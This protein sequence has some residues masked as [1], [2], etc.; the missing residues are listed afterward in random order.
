MFI[1]FCHTSQ[2]IFH[3]CIFFTILRYC[4]KLC[5]KSLKHKLISP[6]QSFIFLLSSIFPLFLFCKKWSLYWWHFMKMLL[7][8][9]EEFTFGS[10][11]FGTWWTR[12]L[13]YLFPFLIEFDKL[14]EAFLAIFILECVNHTLKAAA[15]KILTK[16]GI[17]T[18]NL[19]MINI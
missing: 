16:L 18:L 9:V 5:L 4:Q 19:S 3:W 12:S 6:K 11:K 2:K 10:M 15:L 13:R 8:E 7:W 14:I 17:L 1:H